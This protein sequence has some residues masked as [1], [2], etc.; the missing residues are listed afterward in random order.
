MKSKHD[1]FIDKYHSFFYCEAVDWME[2]KRAKMEDTTA[3]AAL[4]Q[5]YETSGSSI[6]TRALF[7]S[8]PKRFSKFRSVLSELLSLNFFA[9]SLAATS[10]C[11]LEPLAHSA[12][13]AEATGVE[14]G[15]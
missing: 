13:T 10:A 7:E 8:D 3:F 11:A 9:L 2:P 5:H 12:E 14:G 1:V 15:R 6:N 4:K